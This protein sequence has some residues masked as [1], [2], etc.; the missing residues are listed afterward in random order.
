MIRNVGPNQPLSDT[1]RATLD[2]LTRTL[3]AGDRLDVALTQG[4]QSVVDSN[5]PTFGAG[6][7]VLDIHGLGDDRGIKRLVVSPDFDYGVAA[8]KFSGDLSNLPVTLYEVDHEGMPILVE[9][10]TKPGTFR[11]VAVASTLGE[12]KTLRELH[13]EYHGEAAPDSPLNQRSSQERLASL[14]VMLNLD[15][16]S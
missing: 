11:A 6:D 10:E 12:V 1:A 8:S 4:R 15:Q 5:E 3:G 13:N 7:Y 14:A 16:S 9:D 2:C